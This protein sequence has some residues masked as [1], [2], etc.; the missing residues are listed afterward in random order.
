MGGPENY[1]KLEKC[2]KMAKSC[3][4]YEIANYNRNVIIFGKKFDI[5]D[6]KLKISQKLKKNVFYPILEQNVYF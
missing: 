2:V 5:Y 6:R 3:F 4:G 1:Q